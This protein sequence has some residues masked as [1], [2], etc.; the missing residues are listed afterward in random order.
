ML[1]RICDLFGEIICN[2]L[3]SYIVLFHLI[4]DVILKLILRDP[5]TFIESKGESKIG[6]MLQLYTPY[7]FCM[8][9]SEILFSIFPERQSIKLRIPSLFTSVCRWTLF[10]IS[11]TNNIRKFK[12]K[13]RI[14]CYTLLLKYKWNSFSI[15]LNQDCVDN[16]CVVRIMS[17]GLPCE[18]SESEVLH[19]SE[20]CF[21][22]KESEI[23]WSCSGDRLAIST[24]PP[25]RLLACL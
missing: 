5:P 12:L 24:R 14:Q 8:V 1:Y 16:S 25:Q 2:Y 19:L 23:S 10:L 11:L 4:F 9:D 7:T 22:D 3:V 20:L 18:F 15:D 17:T 6:I 13:I 21:T